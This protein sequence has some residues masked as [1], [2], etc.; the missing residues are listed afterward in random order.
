MRYYST[1]NFVGDRIDGY[2]AP[3]SYITREAAEALKKASDAAM[4]DGYRIR[5]YDAYRPQMAV[6][7]FKAWAKDIADT[8]MKEYFYPDLDKSVLFEQGYIASRSGHSRGS[9]IDLTL[10]DMR[11]GHNVDMGGTF[12]YFG[13]LSHPDYTDIT[14]EQYANRMYLRKIM[15]DAGFK[16]LTTEWWHF[17]LA[18]EPY[19][20][21]YFNFP[22]E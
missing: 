22:N 14:A 12:D 7:H 20:D 8:R 21:T 3:V 9:T 2:N 10:F 11:T 17:I 15:V 16:P 4:K 19:P 18:N 6:D 13:E 1:Y 5:V